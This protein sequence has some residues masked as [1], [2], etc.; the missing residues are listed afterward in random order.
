VTQADDKWSI[1]ELSQDGK[2]HIV[3]MRAA[4]PPA[5][6]REL[7][8]NL[9]VIQWRFE[10]DASGMPPEPD[11]ERMQSFEDAL[12]LWVEAKTPTLQALTL[13]GG[14]RKEWRYYTADVDL[15][16][17]SLN[18]VLQED[19]PFPVELLVFE[20]PD[21]IALSEYQDATKPNPAA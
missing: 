18:R 16:M 12:E 7:L 19:S 14:G 15:F 5:A 10:P 11:R 1:A 6:D 17:A 21:W 2:P 13:T 3:R 20:D 8:Q 9:V 4:M